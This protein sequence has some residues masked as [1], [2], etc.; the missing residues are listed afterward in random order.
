MF[1]VPFSSV[2]NW[3]SNAYADHRTVSV[4]V[5]FVHLTGLLMG[6]GT[7]LVADRQILRAARAGLKEREAA[8]SGLNG[9]HRV[10][11]SSLAIIALSG[12]LMAAADWTTFLNSRLFW[13]KMAAVGLLAANGSA[14]MFLERRAVRDS[15]AVRWPGVVAVSAVSFVLWI[16]I[17][18][19]GTLLM[20]AA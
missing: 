4:A 8:L 11:I 18:F 7:A 12:V 6:G 19:L 5:Q 9:S 16:S 2:A 3:W 17:V 20:S 15:V 1:V 14:M 10:V 13:T